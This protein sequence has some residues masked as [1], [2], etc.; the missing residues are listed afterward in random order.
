MGYIPPPETLTKEEIDRR[1]ANGAKTFA[2]L[3]PAFAEWLMSGPIGF[4][5]RLFKTRSYRKLHESIF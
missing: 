2:E 1:I 5:C 3:D 4:F